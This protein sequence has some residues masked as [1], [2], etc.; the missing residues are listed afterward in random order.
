MA[1]PGNILR[2]RSVLHR[3]HRLPDHLTCI[4][5]NNVHAQHPVRLLLRENL[6]AAVRVRVGLGTRVGA[7]GE[8]AQAVRD[9]LSLELLLGLANPGHLG[10]GVDD[11]RDHVV[12]DV[13]VAGLNVLDSSD[14]C[15]VR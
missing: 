7:E 2:T 8:L 6:D 1:R 4:R 12:V 14:A 11:G 3:K 10:V 13:T 15:V 9:A 5:A